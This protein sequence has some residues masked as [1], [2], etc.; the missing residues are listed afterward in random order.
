[1]VDK[2]KQL[3]YVEEG[4]MF[5]WAPEM[6]KINPEKSEILKKFAVG[7]CLDIGFGSG[8]YTEYLRELGHEV[9]GIDSEPEFIKQAQKKY[10]KIKFVLGSVD[11]LPFKKGEFETAILFDVLEHVDDKKVLKEIARVAKRII[12][13]VP[14]ENQEILLRYALAHAHSLSRSNLRNYEVK[15]LRKVMSE[16]GWKVREVKAA[17]PVSISGL[18][19]N[20][21]SGKSLIKRLMLKIVLKPF[22][23]EP[24]LFSTVYGVGDVMS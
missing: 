4:R 1:M 11:K 18:L 15:S 10:P 6:A 9:V 22:L 3:N 19:I 5:G 13:T 2:L 14:H 17:L 23:P 24:P 8:I 20:R 16:N 7:K 21:L 12:I